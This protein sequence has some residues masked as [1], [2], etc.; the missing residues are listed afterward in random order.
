MIAG[1]AGPVSTL[2]FTGGI[3]IGKEWVPLLHSGYD[4]NFFNV[5]ASKTMLTPFPRRGLYVI[6]RES[7]LNPEQRVAEVAAAI[8]GGAAVVQYRVK[9]ATDSVR[10]AKPFLELC[11]SANIPLMINDD[12]ELAKRLGADGVHLGKNDRSLSEAR[13]ILGDQAIIGVSCYDSI[14]LAI[15]AEQEGAAYVAFGRF[16]PSNTKPDA[17]RA[18]LETLILAKQQLRIPIVAIGG[19]TPGN[20]KILLDT[21]ADLLAVIESVFCRDDPEI[22]A[23]QFQSLF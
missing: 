3:P 23:A 4:P 7:Y 6:T 21:G 1:G 11:R 2:I 17:P 15:R 14:D 8:R 9:F 5:R 22:A 19:V 18:H 13:Q 12:V 20:G 16:F 10:E